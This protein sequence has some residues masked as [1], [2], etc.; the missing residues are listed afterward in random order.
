MQNFDAVD[1]HLYV[2]VNT[3]RGYFKDIAMMTSILVFLHDF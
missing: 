3:S 1:P 2:S